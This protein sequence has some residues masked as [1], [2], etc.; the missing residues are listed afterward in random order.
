MEAY[1][2]N[3]EQ[4]V[5][6]AGGECPLDL[7]NSGRVS[8][9]FRPISC[10]V[11]NKSE[12]LRFPIFAPKQIEYVG[13]LTESGRRVY[14]RALC[15][16][17]YKAVSEQYPDAQL[18]IEHSIFRGY[19]CRIFRNGAEG[20]STRATSAEAKPLTLTADDVKRLETKMHDLAAAD[21][22]FERHERLTD[23]VLPV[24]RAQH[25]VSKVLLYETTGQLYT[26]YYTLDGLAD[27]YY[28]AL[29]PSTGYAPVFALHTYAD[30]F[31]LMGRDPKHPSQPLEPEHQDKMFKA[32]TDYMHFNNV[33]KVRN[34]GE[35]NMSVRKKTVRDL[36]TVAE[37]MHERQ[38]GG[39]ADRIV[40][41]GAKIVL[42]AG[43]SSSGKTTTCKRLAVQL[44]TRL[45]TPKMIS[46]D[47]YFVD[48]HVTP[49]DETGD[50]DYE[51]LY[52][53]DLERLNSDLT[54][55]LRGEE[56]NL[57]TYSFELGTRIE[58]HKPLR[59]EASDVLIMEGIHGLN[60]DLIPTISVSNVFK[61][62]VSALTTLS[63]DDH[64]W[65]SP[66]DNRLLRRIVRDFR[67]RS[68]SA[69][70]TIRR[71]PSVRRG[72]EKWIFPFQENADATFNSSLLFEL[73]V[74]KEY[75]EPLL[76][77]VPHNVPQYGNAYRL[78][79][80]LEYFDPIPADQIPQT[81]LL[82]EFLGG[83]S[84]HY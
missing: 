28:G 34:V 48:R 80:F 21:I 1:I 76:R 70:D 61:V 72:E 24:M 33:V 26:T 78:L 60:P 11:N 73:G 58:K 17:L 81:S 71:W 64:N 51:S 77:Q 62:Y 68:T 63:I 23:D 13:D 8:L 52:A 55:L 35:L 67:Y 42:L 39:I 3:L 29:P 18:R 5:E 65:I 82:R 49:R 19:F 84:F 44:M 27:S 50:Y 31:I 16:M 66:N 15:F 22:P 41:S 83:S 7:L 12:D 79:R 36:I 53:L 43:P 56:V 14:T 57:P 30:G 69:L 47:D 25:L 4:Y 54:R 40:E 9:P 75:A 59:M 37:A 6:I 32:F 2:K 74:M 38:I 46:L 45:V 10:F 20:G